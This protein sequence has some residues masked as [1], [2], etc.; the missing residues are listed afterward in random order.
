MQLIISDWTIKTSTTDIIEFL[1]Y[2]LEQVTRDWSA[3]HMS[4]PAAMLQTW[5][6]KQR[7]NFK[8]DIV[9]GVNQA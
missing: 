8:G 3:L 7:R 2:V 4:E 1:V 5:K 9:I 6:A